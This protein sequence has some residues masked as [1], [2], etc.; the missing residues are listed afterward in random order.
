M[1]TSAKLHSSVSSAKSK[2]PRGKV[3]LSLSVG[4]FIDLLAKSLR[5]VHAIRETGSVSARDMT[6]IRRIAATL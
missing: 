3:P 6:K 5:M 4:S 1:T 2:S